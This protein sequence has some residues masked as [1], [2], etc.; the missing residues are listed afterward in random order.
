MKRYLA[1]SASVAGL[2]PTCRI[3]RARRNRLC[4]KGQPHRAS[5]E[6]PRH[7]LVPA[8]HRSVFFA[9]R[10]PQRAMPKGQPHRASE[11]GAALYMAYLTPPGPHCSVFCAALAATGYAE[12]P[13]ASGERVRRRYVY[14][15]PGSAWARMCCVSRSFSRASYGLPP[16]SA[17]RFTRWA[18]VV[19]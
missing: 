6:F 7:P 15:L 3:R 16:L 9:P 11:F 14:G 12:R 8:L 2:Q 5:E 17:F 13:A 10:S 4:R 1:E 18:F 19:W